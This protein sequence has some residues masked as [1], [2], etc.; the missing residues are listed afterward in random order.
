MIIIC[1]GLQKNHR[2][3]KCTFLCDGNWG[4]KELLEHQK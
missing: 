2:Y 3:E 4:D 1:K